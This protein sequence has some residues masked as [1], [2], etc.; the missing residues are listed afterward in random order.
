MLSQ[1]GDPAAKLRLSVSGSQARLDDRLDGL[2]CDCG[3]KLVIVDD[4]QHLL[5]IDTDHQRKA[6][7]DWLK[8]RI[9]NTGV[10]F[11]IVGIPGQIERVL[12]F[13]P[14]LSRLFAMR[15]KLDP[16]VVS[17][18]LSSQ[19]KRSDEESFGEMDYFVRCIEQLLKLD[20]CPSVDRV[21]L[22]Q[23]IYK[24]TGGVAANIV[25]LL[26]FAKGLQPG[27]E[28][29]DYKVLE[30][31]FDYT[32]HHHIKLDKNPFSTKGARKNA[33]S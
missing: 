5:N 2:I 27:L 31:A 21:D 25:L 32:L 29:A 19:W 20:F 28:T 8:V 26:Q 22:L 30:K 11:V 15:E 10:T 16:F 24:A 18:N 9:K 12:D 7:S 17:L 33:T 13:N 4:F 14:Q 1:L 3:V 23:R 6:V